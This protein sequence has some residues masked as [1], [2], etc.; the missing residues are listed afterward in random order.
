VDTFVQD[1]RYAFRTLRSAPGFTAVATITLALGVGVNATIFSVVNAALLRP[2]PVERPEELIDVYRRGQIGTGHDSSSWLDYLDLR[3]RAR[4]LDGLIAYTNFF[5]NLARDSS[6]E[7][8]VGEL[9]S[10]NYF[11]VLG[12]RPALGRAFLPEELGAELTHPV[13]VLS[14]AFWE[15][16]FAADPGVLGQTLRINGTPYAVVGVAPPGFG[17]MFPAVTAQLWVPVTMVEELE[18]IGNQSSVRSPTGD[19]RLTRRGTRWLWMRGRLG[20]GFDAAGA[21]AELAGI[22]AQLA[23]EHPETNERQTVTV[24]P[25]AEVRFN[26]DFDG[27]LAP[28]GMLILGV[29]GLVLLVACANIANMLLARAAARRKEVAVRLALGAGRARLVRQLLTES[30]LLALAGGGAGFAVAVFA[31]RV[32][33]AIQP[34]LPIDLGVD[35]SVDARVFAFTLAASA[36]TGVVFG[37][38]PALRASRPDLV[39]ALKGAA[40]DDAGRAGRFELRDA[41]VVTQV[42]ISMVLL[43]GGALLVRSLASAQRTELGFDADNTSH[44]TVAL[45]MFGYDDNDA[46]VFF[47]TA[48]ARLLDHPGVEAVALTSRAPMSIND[49]NWAVYIDGHQSSAEDRPY[50]IGGAYV[51]AGYFDTLQV[52]L[53]EGR[54]LVPADAEDRR[55]TVV[56]R[57]FAERF[58]PGDSAIG[59]SFRNE[60]AGPEVQIVGVVEDYKTRTVGEAPT[61]YLH[62]PFPTGRTTYAAF[63]VRTR[64]PAAAQLADLERVFLSIDPELVFLDTAPLRELVDVTLFPVRAGA[65]LI[66]VFAALALALAGVGLYGV[67]GYA[68]SRRTHEIGIR[69]ALG[70]ETRRVLALVV[71]RGMVL[72]VLGIGAGTLLSLLAGR[73]LASVLYGIGPTDA[74]AFGA[75]VATLLLVALLANLVPARRAARVDPMVA[76]RH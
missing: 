52:R 57:A 41:L 11:E 5:A 37:L 9:V 44:Y 26:P 55:V 25:T 62:Y 32:I 63:L 15:S 39:P 18:P 56:T 4:S 60:L 7:I 42:A 47:E 23:E 46:A 12:V 34:P 8:V 27:Y 21:Q 75:A 13:A 19:T 72:V 51:D 74:I 17:G 59:K 45:D 43:V 53:L 29:V 10:D 16:R 20:D 2:L 71:T 58:W 50:V 66:G 68:V 14:H 36:L 67:I 38:A 30:L 64:E 76:L 31:T 69:M 6:S 22:M 33:A 28:A 24:L 61:P 35:F 73:V 48:R 40:V 3:E 65:L 1:L 70:A 49:N 54:L